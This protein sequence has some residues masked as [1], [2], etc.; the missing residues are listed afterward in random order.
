[1]NATIIR[2]TAAGLLLASLATVGVACSNG[3]KEAPSTSTTTTTTTTT[4]APAPTSAPPV[5][6]TEKSINPTGGNLFTP[7]V[8]APGPQTAA[9]GNLPGNSPK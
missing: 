5:E 7:T 8:K 3:E 9:P 4:T 1:M 6:P 2:R